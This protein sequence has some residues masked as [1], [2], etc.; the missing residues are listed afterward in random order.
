MVHEQCHEKQAARKRADPK[1][2]K[3]RKS[4][5]KLK[6]IEEAVRTI[7]KSVADSSPVESIG[8]GG[9]IGAGKIR[10]KVSLFRGSF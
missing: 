10:N 8:D 1:E 5:S 9:T 2:L 4:K 3:T 6:K 7:C